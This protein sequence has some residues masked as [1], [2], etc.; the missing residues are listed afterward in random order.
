MLNALK[1]LF[2]CIKFPMATYSGDKELQSNSEKN[3]KTLVRKLI[4]MRFKKH[5]KQTKIAIPR[6]QLLPIKLNSVLG[7]QNLKRK[8]TNFVERQSSNQSKATF[9]LI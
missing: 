5:R 4:K 9:E 7:A 1:E 3:I 2:T 6:G 8:P